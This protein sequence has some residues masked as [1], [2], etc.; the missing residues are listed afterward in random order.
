MANNKLTLTDTDG[1][2]LE[3]EESTSPSEGVAFVR[4]SSSG[5]YLTARQVRQ[6]IDRLEP[7]AAPPA[8]ALDT[9][10]DFP[11]GQVFQWSDDRS[12]RVKVSKSHYAVLS[13][14]SGKPSVYEAAD[15]L[16]DKAADRI[17]AVS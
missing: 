5:V 9:F 10:N 12:K 6:L 3:I 13:A 16:K 8:T 11:L 4:A 2:Y 14:H 7:V 15:Q 1:D 17:K